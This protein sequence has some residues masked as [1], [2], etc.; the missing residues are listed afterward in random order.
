[1]AL[2]AELFKSVFFEADM[3]SSTTIT[4]ALTVL[5]V[6]VSYALRKDID[7]LST[8]INTV[9]KKYGP[10]SRRAYQFNSGIPVAAIVPSTDILDEV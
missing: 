9:E 2:A 7:R 4:I 10:F 1:M 8:M 6:P 5:D 3:N